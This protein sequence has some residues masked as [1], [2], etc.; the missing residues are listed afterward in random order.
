MRLTGREESAINGVEDYCRAQ[1]LW[2]DV[3]AAEKSYTALLELDLNTVRPALAGP[4]RPQD[5]VDLADMKTHFV[6][7]LTAELGHLDWP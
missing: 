6:E 2:Y 4:K 1:G 5:R 7:S 3:N